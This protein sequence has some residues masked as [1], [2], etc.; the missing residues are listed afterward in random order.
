MPTY[1]GAEINGAG[2]E[3]NIIDNKSQYFHYALP[4]FGKF[5]R[6][7]LKDGNY[8]RDEEVQARQLVE[9]LRILD[10]TGVYGVFVS[11]FVS[12]IIPYDK[13]PKFDLDMASMSLVKTYSGSGHGMTFPDMSWEP[14]ESFRA[15][16]DY[17]AKN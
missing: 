15:V 8:I 6:P 3:G 12:Q 17:Y 1:Q 7:K 11:S 13:D 2:L 10:K 4:L 14:K 16:A 5:I 9:Q